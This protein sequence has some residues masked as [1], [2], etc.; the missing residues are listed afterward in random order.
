MFGHSNI[1]AFFGTY[2]TNINIILFNCNF[3]NYL[4]IF[5]KKY[6]H[7]NLFTKGVYSLSYFMAKYHLLPWNTFDNFYP[8]VS[9]VAYYT[10]FTGIF[11]VWLNARG[12][13]KN[14]MLKLMKEGK[15]M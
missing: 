5:F 11:C 14:S 12:V 7:L 2:S 13:H 9:R 10:P 3:L 6:I 4:Y 1:S 15:A 8:L